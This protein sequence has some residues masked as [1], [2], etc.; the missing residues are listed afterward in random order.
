VKVDVLTTDPDHHWRI[1][2]TVPKRVKLVAEKVES[3]EAFEAA[4]KSGY[5]LFQGYYFSKPK[6]FAARS[7][8]GQRT[9]YV[10][11]LAELNKPNATL[12]KIEDL[13][14]HDGA[15]SYRVLRCINSAAYGLRTT[16]H[17]IRQALVLLG[18]DQVRKWAS[19]WALAGLNGG[20]NSEIVNLAI[21]RARSCELIAETMLGRDNASEYFLLGLCSLLDTML[22]RPMAESLD[23]L[24]VSDEVR[25]ALLGDPG[26]PR[27]ILDAILAYE[28]GH[29]DEAA[30]ALR[31]VRIDSHHLPLAY[32]DALKWARELS[33]SA[34]A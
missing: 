12:F 4:R 23:E 22:G 2:A 9:A 17:S 10:Q 16:L 18:L 6:T 8:T 1:A 14:K 19:V 25:A 3:I 5:H 31:T 29:W 15:L 33:H 32:A 20:A 11:L 28:R 26:K 30:A 27:T 24:P 34:A 21:V 13:I 7:I